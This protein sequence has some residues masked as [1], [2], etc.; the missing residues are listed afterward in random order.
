M[1]VSDWLF[2]TAG[3]AALLIEIARWLQPGT[4]SAWLAPSLLVIAFG[5]VAWRLLHSPRH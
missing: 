3:T 5:A 2:V 4:F 1:R